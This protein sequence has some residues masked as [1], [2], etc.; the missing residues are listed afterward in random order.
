[1][2][3]GTKSDDVL[4]GDAGNNRLDGLDGNDRLF[5][6]GGDDL[7]IGGAGVDRLDGGAGIDMASYYSSLAAVAV[8]LTSHTA[9]GGDAQGDVLIGIEDLEGSAW[10]DTLTGDGGSNWLYGGAGADVLRGQ[11]GDDVLVGGAGADTLVGGGGFDAASYEGSSGAVAVNLATGILGAGDAEGDKL[12]QISA[13]IGSAFNDFLTG[14][15]QGSWLS[16]GGGI[17][18]LVGGAGDDTLLGGAG[19]DTLMGAAGDDL[20]NGGAGADTL[21]GG[22]GYNAAS[23]SRSSAAVAVDLGTGAV[24]AGDAQGDKLYQI[25]DVIGSAFNDFLTGN[26]GGNWLSGGEGID[27]LAGGA[28]DDTVQGGAG[29]DILYGG[30]G[31]DLASYFGSRAGVVVNLAQHSAAGGDAQG[32]V[33]NSIEDLEGSAWNDVLTGDGG[34]NWLYGGDGADRL[35]GLDGDD[36]LHGG[37]GADVL[38]GGV[39]VNAAS[40]AGSSAGVSINLL[41]GKG[42]LGDANGDILIGISDLI[43][44]SFADSLRGSNGDNWMNGGAGAD[45]L[46]GED[47]NDTLRGGAGADILY[48]GAGYNMASYLGSQTGVSVDLTRSFG[49]YGD[50]EGDR[51]YQI[52][53]LNGSDF[54]DALKGN[55]GENWLYGGAGADILQGEGGDD[56]LIGGAG[57]DWLVGGGGFDTVSYDGSSSAVAVNLATG[58]LGAGEAEGDRLSGISGVIGSAFNDFLTASALGSW[59]SGGDGIDLLAGGAGNDSLLGGAGADTLYGGAGFNAASYSTSSAGVSVDLGTGAVGAGDAQG[60]KLYQITDVIGSGF[61]DFLTGDTRNN[62]LSGGAGGDLLSG[63]S[64]K[65]FLQGGAGA[66]VLAGGAGVDIFIYSDAADSG[67][68]AATRD[69]IVDFHWDRDRIDLSDIDANRIANG[70][71]TFAY[72]GTA[73]FSGVAGQLRYAADGGVLVVAADLNGDRIADFTIAIEGGVKTLAA[74]DFIL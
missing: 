16:G 55:N 57:A 72:I 14:N 47:G 18:L 28:G 29:A 3:A 61:N 68:T 19:A 39:G 30:V 21:Y 33:L 32:D 56:V 66:D 11:G 51:L 40:Y 60:D 8:N 25:T 46:M 22:A 26:S 54:D 38:D 58:I 41:T 69:R 62:W 44:S 10:N 15:A 53:D 63:G 9:S 35:V 17:D 65:D 67:F 20:L 23:Y 12:S 50:A 45:T 7:L 24:G 13:V 52:T 43:G 4:T 70:N 37:A 64:G 48:G 6:L 42:S 73:A 74:T 2:V 27:L 34:G 71:Q 31:S 1:M 59:L 49:H 36:L 5:G